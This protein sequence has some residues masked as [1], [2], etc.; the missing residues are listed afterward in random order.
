MGSGSYQN[1]PTAC[2][3]RRINCFINGGAARAFPSP[4]APNTLTSKKSTG[5]VTWAAR[6]EHAASIRIAI[7]NDLSGLT[8]WLW[9]NILEDDLP[10]IML[11][12]KRCLLF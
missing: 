3:G 1:C 12:G 10:M 7:N 9:T 6:L 2:C 8:I 5:A 4:F 11:C